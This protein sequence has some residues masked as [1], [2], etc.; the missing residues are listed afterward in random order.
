MKQYIHLCEQI[1]NTGQWVKNK[2]TDKNCLTVINTDFTYYPDKFPILTTRKIN[3]KPAIA[4][5]LGYMRGYNNAKS[6]RSLGTKTW[7]ANANKNKAWLKNPNRQGTD[8]LGRIYGVQGRRWIS[9]DGKVYDQLKKVINDLTV[10]IDDRSEIVTFYNPAELDKGCL[11]PCMHTYN[12]SLLGDGLYLTAYQ[13]SADVP[14]G[15]A[16]NMM[17]VYFL[18]AIVA[19]ITGKNAK[20]AYHKIANAHVY[21][22]QLPS[23]KQQIKRE[24]LSPPLEF[25]INPD[26]KTLKDLET[27]VTVDDF[28][29]EGYAYH[30]PIKYTFSV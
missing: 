11:V 6:F 1:I 28:R 5:M 2:R 17:Q 8:D 25:A 4:E 18:L 9:A 7:D 3:W 22:D 26:I 20:T 12:F 13:R 16:Y 27:W 15:L 23:I 10:G 19:Q 14:L 21:E 30:P 24:P 29:V